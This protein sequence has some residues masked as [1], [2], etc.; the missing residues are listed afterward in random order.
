MVATRARA[1]ATI[2]NSVATVFIL[3]WINGNIRIETP[4]CN[5]GLV[6]D[7]VVQ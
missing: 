1:T 5:G 4:Q 7:Q 3:A 6:V 2:K